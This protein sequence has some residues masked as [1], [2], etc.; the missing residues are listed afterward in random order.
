[1]LQGEIFNLLEVVTRSRMG[2]NFQPRNH[3]RRIEKYVPPPSG[4]FL[5]SMKGTIDGPSFCETHSC[6]P[7]FV[8]SIIACIIYGIL[9][10]GMTYTA[11]KAYHL[12]YSRLDNVQLIDLHGAHVVTTDKGNKEKSTIGQL[13]NTACHEWSALSPPWGRLMQPNAVRLYWKNDV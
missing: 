9:H 5:S 11:G 6:L 13:V 3:C 2:D 10:N 8:S 12:P 1:M 7:V 4:T